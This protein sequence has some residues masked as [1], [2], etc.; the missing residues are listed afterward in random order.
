MVFLMASLSLFDI[1]G[2]IYKKNKV[3][4]D[5]DKGYLIIIN[6]WLSL[7]KDNIPSLNR[8]VKYLFFI[9]PEH[10]YYLL[11]F[12]IPKKFRA[13]FLKTKKETKKEPTELVQRIQSFF[14]WSQNELNANIDILG[15]T[16]LKN[17]K[18]WKEQFGL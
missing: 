10:Y 13:P 1:L 14:G 7:D 16:V 3:K 5:I 4:P 2:N 12:N 6:K 17:E 15:R 8:I 11:F 18:Y 9:N